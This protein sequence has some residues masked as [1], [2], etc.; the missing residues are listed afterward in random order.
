MKV[1]DLTEIEFD[2]LLKECLD[3]LNK[4]GKKRVVVEQFT[5]YTDALILIDDDLEINSQIPDNPIKK[6][7]DF[8]LTFKPTKHIK[9]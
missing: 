3:R 2:D 4:A 7:I 9:P 8:N 5:T 6:W 1:E